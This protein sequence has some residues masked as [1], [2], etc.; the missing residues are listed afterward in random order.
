MLT[1]CFVCYENATP[2]TQALNNTTDI[3][4]PDSEPQ[5]DGCLL[6]LPEKGG[7]TKVVDGWLTGPP[8]LIGEIASTTESY[9]LHGKKQD[10]ERQGIKEYI[11]V[12]LWQRRVFLF[13]Q[14]NGRF[15]ELPPGPDGVFRSEVFPGLWIDPEA[16]LRSDGARLFEVLQ[17]GLATPEHQ[18]FVSKLA[19]KT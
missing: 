16:L 7:Q 8:E 9:D 13:I 15:E 2:G 17:K 12:A 1:F 19:A 3:L 14:R 4:G 10:Y 5:P 6:I 11:V 18:E